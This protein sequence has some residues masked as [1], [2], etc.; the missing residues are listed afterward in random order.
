[1]YL[2]LDQMG[3]CCSRTTIR[4]GLLESLE[5]HMYF[6]ACGFSFCVGMI[7]L[8]MC[9]SLNKS[10]SAGLELAFGFSSYQQDGI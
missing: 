8:S 7:Y 2:D 6:C 3:S 10:E 4:M 9:P 1:M 5:S